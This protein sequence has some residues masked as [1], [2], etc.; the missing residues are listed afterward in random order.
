MSTTAEAFRV[1]PTP[2]RADGEY[3]A[4]ARISS[5]RLDGAEYDVYLSG[6][7]AA[8]ELREDAIAYARNWARAWLQA[9]YG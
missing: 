6:D 5:N 4:H 8:F 7:L 1:D 2:R 3:I 9:A